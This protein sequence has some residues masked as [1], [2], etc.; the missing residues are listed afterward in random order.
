MPS[1]AQPAL[2]KTRDLAL[3][4]GELFYDTGLPCRHG[5]LSKRYTT[6]GSCFECVR[7]RT[8]AQRKMYQEGKKRR[9]E[10]IAQQQQASEAV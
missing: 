9:L 5:H 10:K 3:C 8:D 6:S 4:K 7:L 1:K 2:P